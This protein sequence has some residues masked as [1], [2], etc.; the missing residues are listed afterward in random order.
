MKAGL[1]G[2]RNQEKKKRIKIPRRISRIGME[3]GIKAG[4]RN[5]R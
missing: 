4:G 2:G 1:R 5:V 3:T